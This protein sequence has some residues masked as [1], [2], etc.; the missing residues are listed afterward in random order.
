V[1]MNSPSNPT[2]AV[3]SRA[4][5]E[6]LAEVLRPREDVIVVSDEIYE[7]VLYDAEHVAFAALPGM[8]ERTVTGNGFSKAFAMTGWRLGYLAAP[9]WI[10]TAAGTVQGQFTSAPSTIT[11]RAGI[12]ALAM[13][14]GPVR[15]M[16]RAFRERR[17]F[18]LG[19]L[20]EIPDV[21]CPTPEGAF[22]VF[23]DVSAYFGRTAPDGRVIRNS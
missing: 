14:R 9:G 3:Y 11:Q 10:A 19:A 1:M 18:V 2:G 7:H 15:E 8:R 23:P 21:L 13:D 6:A 20:E 22:Y 12:A 16:V 4:E 17:D 5:L